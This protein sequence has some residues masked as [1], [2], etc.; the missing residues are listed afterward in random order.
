MRLI[1]EHLREE[2]V[3][4]FAHAKRS[5]TFG[6]RLLALSMKAFLHALI[7]GLCKRSTSDGLK[8]MND[9]IEALMKKEA[10]ESQQ[11]HDRQHA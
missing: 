4:Y 9:E 7:P 6:L 5:T 8:C 1:T 2:N 11:N 10:C 3:G